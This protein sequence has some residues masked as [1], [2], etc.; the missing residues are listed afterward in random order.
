MAAD[1]MNGVRKYSYLSSIN[2]G[3]AWTWVWREAQVA[4]VFGVSTTVVC[5]NTMDGYSW[6]D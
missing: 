2:S 5:S 3:R 1:Y 4:A 6:C